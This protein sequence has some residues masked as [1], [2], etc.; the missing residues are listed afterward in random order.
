MPPVR[1]HAGAAERSGG[2]AAARGAPPLPRVAPVL[3]APGV[4][5]PLAPYRVRGLTPAHFD[6]LRENAPVRW[7]V[8]EALRTGRLPLWNPH[9]AA[10]M[11]LHAEAIHGPLHR[12]R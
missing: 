3:V 5:A 4:L 12:R 7:L 8:G 10:G 2:A 1:R 11:P 6:T 9:A